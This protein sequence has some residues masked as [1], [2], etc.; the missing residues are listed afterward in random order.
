ML[1]VNA[2]MNKFREVRTCKKNN[3]T[4]L[5]FWNKNRLRQ[6]CELQ[7]NKKVC[8]FQIFLSFFGQLAGFFPV[9]NQVSLLPPNS[10]LGKARR[11]VCPQVWTRPQAL[12]TQFWRRG[13]FNDPKY[14]GKMR[15]MT[16][17]RP[18]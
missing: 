6:A 12:Y 1:P 2:L 3:D 8:A 14:L 11:N 7:Y 13:G 15:G 5:G 16:F 9:G 18:E 17:S 10:G 4:G